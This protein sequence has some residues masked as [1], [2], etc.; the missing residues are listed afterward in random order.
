MLERKFTELA[1]PV[2]GADASAA[3]VERLQG[4]E[5]ERDVSALLAHTRRAMSGR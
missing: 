4:L 1:V 2:L 3:V 5:T